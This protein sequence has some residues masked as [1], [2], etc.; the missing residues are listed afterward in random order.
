[1]AQII[2][3]WRGFK[4]VQT[5]GI[6]LLQGDLIVNLSKNTLKIFKKSSSLEPAAQIQPNLVQIILG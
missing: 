4:Y 6:A 3:G 5:K 1:L 2:L